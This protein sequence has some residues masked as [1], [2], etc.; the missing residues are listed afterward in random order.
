M[1]YDTNVIRKMIKEERTKH[2]MTQAELGRA[3]GITSKQVSNYENRDVLPPLDIP[4]G[5]MDLIVRRLTVFV[6][7]D[8]T[9]SFIAFPISHLP[10]G[11]HITLRPYGRRS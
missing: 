2:K 6:Q 3:L 4:A 9:G 5:P 10:D 1:R 7:N 8:G 11:L